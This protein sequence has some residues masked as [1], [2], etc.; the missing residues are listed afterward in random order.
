MSAEVQRHRT[1]MVRHTLSQ[2]MSLAVRHGLVRPG[3]TV[4]D[5][6]CGQGDDLR[7]LAAAGIEA[8]G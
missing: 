2:P 3:V 5:Y 6:G 4:F 8:N 7:A 1:A